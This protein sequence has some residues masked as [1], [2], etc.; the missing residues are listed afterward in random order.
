MKAAGHGRRGYVMR[1]Q[2]HEGRVEGRPQDSNERKGVRDYGTRVREERS[3]SSS[4]TKKIGD[5]GGR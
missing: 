1:K 5:K 2:K 4:E 3:K